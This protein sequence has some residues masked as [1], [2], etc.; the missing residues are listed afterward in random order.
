MSVQLKPEKVQAVSDIKTIFE[1]SSV[2]I[3]ADYRGLAAGEVTKLRKSLRAEGARLKV[4]KNTLTRIALNELGVEV[5][6]DLF[7]G[8]SL[9]INTVAD[10]VKASK[11]VKK[12]SKEFEKLVIKGGVLERKAIRV[13]DVET[14]AA[15]PSREEL[16]AK[17]LGAMKSPIV[18][19]I[20]SLSS[21]LRGLVYVLKAIENQKNK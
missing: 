3:V 5:P 7:T 11:V 16:I 9:I 8:P 19:T 20:L 6:G 13:S 14:L 15:L 17:A 18:K 2:V 21:P 4:Y 10:P 1:T 12:F